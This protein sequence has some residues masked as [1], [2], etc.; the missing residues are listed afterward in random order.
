LE[1]DDHATSAQFPRAASEEAADAL[2]AKSGRVM[3]MRLSQVHDTRRQG[4][5]TQHIR[6]ARQKGYVACVG[7]GRNRLPAVHIRDAVGLYRLAL[8]NGH[9]GARYNAVAEEGVAL[10]DIAQV[11]GAGL[12]LPVHSI[13]A[14]DAPDYFGAIA[15]LVAIDLAASSALTRQRLDWNPTGPDLLTDLRNMDYSAA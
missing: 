3:V 5:I 13:T 9:A 15:N 4:R 11:I 7:E 8:E 1:T 2:I 10:R 14:Q 6:L 12:K